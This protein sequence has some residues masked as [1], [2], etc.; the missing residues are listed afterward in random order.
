MQQEVAMGEEIS[1]TGFL[2][3]MQAAGSKIQE[4]CQIEWQSYKP[5]QR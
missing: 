4:S 3:E 2:E 5:N 1:P